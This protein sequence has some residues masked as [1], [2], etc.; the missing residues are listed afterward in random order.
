MLI[1]GASKVFVANG[2]PSEGQVF[3]KMKQ[4]KT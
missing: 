3:T 2:P 4:A 1:A